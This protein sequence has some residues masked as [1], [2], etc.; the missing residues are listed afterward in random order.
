MQ[1]MRNQEITHFSL[2]NG[3]LLYRF[4]VKIGLSRE[5]RPNYGR[6]IILMTCISWVPLLVLSILEGVA[7]GNKVDL[8]FIRD[9][10]P[11]ARLLLSVPVFIIADAVVNRN[12]AQ[13]VDHLPTSG[14]IPETELP[15]WQELLGD[16]FR[17]S[18]ATLPDIILMVVALA[19]SWMVVFAS[20]E[21]DL[22]KT[23]SWA[24]TG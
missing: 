11:H 19:A 12:L 9:I 22:A 8:P 20:G 18:R 6:R 4:F 2:G 24:W 17:R 23:S 16:L 15:R 10:G 1:D 13:V 3:G 7:F 21:T 14:L 5:D